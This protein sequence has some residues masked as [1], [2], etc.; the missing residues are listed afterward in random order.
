MGGRGGAGEGCAGFGLSLAGGVVV[1]TAAGVV[2]AAAEVA[3][4]VVVVVVVLALGGLSVLAASPSPSLRL[5]TAGWGVL[6]PPILPLL[7][8]RSSAPS[9]LERVRG[10]SS[11]SRSSPSAG[12]GSGVS[13]A[14]GLN[15]NNTG[16]KKVAI[17]L[18]DKHHATKTTAAYNMCNHKQ[19]ITLGKVLTYDFC[20]KLISS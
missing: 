20:S 17:V 6:L 16:G 18:C 9:G 12:P 4:T 19:V 15:I 7:L 8:G 14:A 11:T 3:A 1:L 13:M 10:L 5:P 2:A